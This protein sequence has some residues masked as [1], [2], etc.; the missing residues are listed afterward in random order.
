MNDAPNAA[1]DDPRA[2]WWRDRGL[3]WLLAGAAALRLVLGLHLWI[4]DPLTRALLSDA[5]FY[6]AWARTEVSGET[7]LA[8][9]PHWLPPLYPWILGLFYRAS[10]GALALTIAAQLAVGVAVTALVARLAWSVTDRRTGLVAGWMWTLYMPVV[11]FETRL[12]GVNAALPL[13]VVVLLAGLAIVR[14][15][16]VGRAAPAAA[17]LAGLAAGVACLARPNLLL[18]LPGAGLGALISLA[19]ARR[20][21]KPRVLLGTAAVAGAGLAVGLA[22]GWISNHSR[23]GQSVLVSANG[24]V[25]FWFGNNAQAHG[26]FHAPG[27]EWG[28]IDEQR[29]VSLAIA[30]Q[31]LGHEVDESEASAWWFARGRAWIAEHP[32]DALGLWGLKLA[33]N[34]SS[35]EFGIQYVPASIRADAPGLWLAPLPFGLILG[36]AA[37]GLGRVR[38]AG[39][40]LGWIAA[41]LAAGLLYFTYS[42]FRLPWIPALLPFSAAG[43]VRLV[44][45]MR[46]RERPGARGLVALVIGLGLAA[47]SWLPFEGDYPRQ[48]FDHARGDAATGWV[49]LGRES[50]AQGA[51][52]VARGRFERALA[53]EPARAD[54][55]YE[56]A[57]VLL[58][59]DDGR[60]ADPARALELLEQWT[61]A[62][63]KN[64][65]FRDELEVLLG[66]ALVTARPAD[67]GAR[68]RARGLAQAVL[69]RDPEHAGAARLLAE[70]GR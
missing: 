10:G 67:F 28:A 48:L 43:A 62:A 52:R 65:P 32:A 60:T 12:L 64:D 18:A 40:L 21:P 1:A 70:L 61:A 63:A 17:A 66:A 36:L 27:P 23:S 24:G 35:T 11:L 19:L 42:R 25:N 20:L 59:A 46:G 13:C 51:W 4:S 6:D 16:E 5:A 7:W 55:V 45:W 47:Q 22:P 57:G 30:A 69:E 34:L 2:P 3:L 37:L 41:G 58:R 8:G 56:L 39:A 14:S 26:T 29:D 68:A 9:R 31:D 38:Q 15:L 53:I 54:A 44:E 49:Q 50:T 33:D